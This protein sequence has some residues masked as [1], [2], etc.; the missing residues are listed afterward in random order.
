MT[1]QLY[2]KG[3][4]TSHWGQEV[5]KPKKNQ[6]STYKNEAVSVLWYECSVYH[7]V[8]LTAGS[9]WQIWVYGRA[10]F[11]VLWNNGQSF[12]GLQ[13]WVSQWLWL[14]LLRCWGGFFG[15]W[16][17]WN[18][19]EIDLATVRTDRAARDIKNDQL[20]N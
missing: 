1:G 3:S 13:C 20:K 18:C 17:L 6:P 9:L 11:G 14:F 16:W 4:K 8:L 2:L 12:Y 5:L 15:D 19:F 10:R 7:T